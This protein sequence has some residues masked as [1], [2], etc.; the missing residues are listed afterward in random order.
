MRSNPEPGARFATP[1]PPRFKRRSMAY[2][3][4]KTGNWQAEAAKIKKVAQKDPSA[5][6]WT[7]QAAFRRTILLGL[8]FLSAALGACTL[9]FILTEDHATLLRWP[10]LIFFTMLFGWTAL[11]FW[12]AVSGFLTLT[13]RGDRFDLARLS[14]ETTPI[15]DRTKTCVVMPIYNEDPAL[16]FSGLRAVYRSLAQTGELEHFDFFVLSDSSDPDR[17]VTEEVA[18]AALCGELEESDRIYYRHRRNRIQKKSGNIADFCRRWGAHYKYMIVLDADSLITGDLALKM[19]RSMEKRPDIGIL[20]TMPMS[21]NQKSLIARI[22]QFSNHVYGP[23]FVAGF[24]SWQL[25]DAGFW[26]H[27]AIVRVEPFMKFCALPKLPGKLPFG[28]DILSHDFVEAALLRRA[29][30]GV[31]IAYDLPGSYEQPPPHLLEELGRDRRW[32]QGNIQHL[33]LLGMKGLSWGHRALFA[34]G[35][36]FYFSSLVWLLFLV[37]A[38]VHLAAM[39]FQQPDYFPVAHGLFPRWPVYHYV[40]SGFLLAATSIFLLAPKVM[41]VIVLGKKG[42]LRRFGGASK[43]WAGVLLETLSSMLLAPIRMLF[44]SRFTVT[45]LLRKNLDWKA[46]GHSDGSIGLREAARACG[47]G[48]ALAFFWGVAVFV[49]DRTF[50]WWFSVFLIPLAFS[51]P[52][53]MASSRTDLGQAFRRRGLFVI[54]EENEPPQVLRDLQEGLKD[55]QSYRFDDAVSDPAVHSLH[56]SLLGDGSARR[57]MPAIVQYRR[58]LIEKASLGGPGG[59][60]AKE[61]I[62]LLYDSRSITDLHERVRSGAW[63]SQPVFGAAE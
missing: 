55:I 24:H 53:T 40:L 12:I 17:W 8:T 57:L 62:R 23:L 2:Q 56:R 22:H 44:H 51:I 46:S 61:K 28:G 31:W 29:G 15:D 47:S 4:L 1:Q 19:V 58:S 43:V 42:Q 52:L 37:S 9:N 36:L 59:L 49:I 34:L 54:P 14:E 60:S 33:R 48:T 13:G 27:N 30:Y 7:R 26:G 41:A 25:G 32:C 63:S 18:W 3:G 6:S 45:A 20:Q 16:V 21:V 39:R 11:N 10:T 38:T 35:N 50:F 5:V